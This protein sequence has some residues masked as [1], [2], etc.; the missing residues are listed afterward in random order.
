MNRLILL[1]IITSLISSG[2]LARE[3]GSIEVD[4]YLNTGRAAQYELKFKGKHCTVETNGKKDKVELSAA[5]HKA[6]LLAL[7]SEVKRY[8]V[9]PRKFSS[10][11]MES[12]SVAGEHI[13]LEF[14]YKAP[15]T[16]LEIELSIPFDAP[17]RLSR[18]MLSVIEQHF[19]I[20]LTTPKRPPNKTNGE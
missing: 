13:G 4:Y 1:A 14:K 16:E 18:E 7:Q 15:G 20:D 3:D 6:I 9:A 5:Q 10:L 17:S 8:T 2:A 11:Q 19:K 12:G